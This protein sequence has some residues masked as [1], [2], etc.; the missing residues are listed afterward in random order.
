MEGGRGVKGRVGV[1]DCGGF[2][3][4]KEKGRDCAKDLKSFQNVNL[5]SPKMQGLKEGIQTKHN[6]RKIFPF[7]NFLYLGY[8]FCFLFSFPLTEAEICFCLFVYDN[9]LK[10]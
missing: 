9:I 2:V 10:L 1:W 8:I 6:Q 5:I 3:G 7:L 4:A